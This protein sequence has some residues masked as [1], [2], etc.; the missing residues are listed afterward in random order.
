M[1]ILTAIVLS[2]GAFALVACGGDDD[3][4]DGGGEEP[5]TKEEYV[6]Q[7]QQI[8]DDAQAQADEV[9][10]RIQQEVGNDPA[11]LEG[12]I[13]QATQELVPIVRDS[14]DR[15]AALTPPEDLQDAEDRFVSA[16]DELF[17]QA[18][19]DPSVLQSGEQEDSPEAQEAEDAA[20]ELGLEGCFDQAESESGETSTSAAPTP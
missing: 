20:K 16:T 10:A 3:G 2:V 5:L 13:T 18:E 19:E 11:K 15:I 6:A 9:S 7:A 1:K 4:G 8:C 12:A 17:A 14:I